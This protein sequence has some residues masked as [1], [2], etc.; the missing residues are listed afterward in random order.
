[1][2]MIG[3]FLLSAAAGIACITALTKYL[4]QPISQLDGSESCPYS[5]EQLIDIYV[6]IYERRDD[7]QMEQLANWRELALLDSKARNANVVDQ[8]ETSGNVSFISEFRGQGK[9]Q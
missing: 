1:M 8:A 9:H 6:G 5:S 3:I 4:T 7:D 2:Y